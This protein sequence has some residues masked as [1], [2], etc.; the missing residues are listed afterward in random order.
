MSAW[1]AQTGLN[2]TVRSYAKPSGPKV[3]P[4]KRKTAEQL[5]DPNKMTDQQ[6]LDQYTRMTYGL[7]KISLRKR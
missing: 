6:L 2:G 7:T 4:L 3:T 1:D 5:L